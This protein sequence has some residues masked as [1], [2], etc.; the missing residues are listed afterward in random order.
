MSVPIDDV[1]VAEV[2]HLIDAEGPSTDEEFVEVCR[3]VAEAQGH[4]SDA[5]GLDGV[6]PVP[7]GAYKLMTI[8]CFAPSE[9][10]AEFRTSGTTTGSPGRHLVRDLDLYRRSVLRGFDRFVLRA[11]RPTVW[12]SLIPSAADRPHSSLSHMVSIL[13]EAFAP[14]RAVFARRGP[15]LA[16]DLAL[17]VLA[18]AATEGGRPPVLLGTTLDFL[19]LFDAF[20]AGAANPLQLPAGTR[21]MHT[22]GEKASGR[23]LSRA[24]LWDGFAQWLG[25]PSDDVAEEYGMTELLSQAYDAPRVTAG[26]RRLRPVPWMRTRILDARTM[27]DVAPGERGLVCHY[28]LANVHTAVAVLTN[29]LATRVGDGFAQIARLPGA[30]ARGCSSEASTTAGWPGRRDLP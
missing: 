3:A 7:E 12:L 26:P 8:A 15:E 17:P 5:A 29:D 1:L 16:L 13:A 6:T 28:D 10:Q 18:G 25:V 27:D 4:L 30:V 11:E 2:R 22:G 19:T 20:A 14:G 21:V 23:S 9:A 24:E